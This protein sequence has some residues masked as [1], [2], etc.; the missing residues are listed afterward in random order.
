MLLEY[1]RR[2]GKSAIFLI[3]CAVV[4]AVIFYLYNLPWE[5][6]GYG[7]L[8]C[9]LLGLPLIIIDYIRFFR[10]RQELEQLLD[11]AEEPVLSLPPPNGAL[12]E[13][14]QAL[15]RKMD[16]RCRTLETETRTKV[17]NMTDYYSLWVHQIK[18]PIAA[19][20][21]LLNEPNAA[22]QI[23]GELLKIEQYVEM[24]LG[25][26]RLDSESTDYLFRDTEIDPLIRAALRKLAR[27][28][29]LQKLSL[30]FQETGIIALTDGKWLL[31]V[32]EQV[33]TNAVKYTPAGGTVW[34]YRE[35]ESLLIRDTGIGIRAEDLPRV[36]DKGFTGFNG[37]QERK[38]T[39]IGLYLCR[40]VMEKLGH[41]ISISSR[42]GEG[43]MVRLGLGREK[44]IM[45]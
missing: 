37:R 26:L 36:F 12:E 29:I 13:D 1:L 41:T 44:R 25:Y 45:E 14:Y 16:S 32:V 5:A 19:A 22:P 43:T 38:S 11:K 6:A 7:G 34:I 4:T 40:Q 18:T 3:G 20:R 8:L 27:L 31:F 35:G 30:D 2:H 21:L 33:L 10:R 15:L 23:E 17:Q 9:L 42:P 24:V 39:G 28:F